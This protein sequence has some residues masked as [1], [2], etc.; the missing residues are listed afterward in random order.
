LEDQR[1]VLEQALEDARRDAEEAST[2]HDRALRKLHHSLEKAERE[3]RA[4]APAQGL[5][6]HGK[7]SSN[8]RRELHD[9]LRKT[10]SE[11]DALEHDLRQQ[12]ETIDGLVMAESSLR[13]KLERA[14]GERAA[15]RLS[16]EKLQRDVK[17]MKLL[18]AA[19]EDRRTVRFAGE[20]ENTAISTV[21]RAAEGAEKRHN[22]EI[23][24]MVM[25][26]EWMQARWEREV[27]M[28]ADAAYAKKFLQLELE[29]STAW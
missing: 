16:A 8:E 15:Y 22:K 4:A 10:Q 20:D 1:I 11:A 2:R 27:K 7:M 26:M 23:R 14:R 13:K 29:V 18:P 5:P 9:M 24:G 12:Q 28:R 25:Q 19:H 6:N 21:V 17:Q 3:S